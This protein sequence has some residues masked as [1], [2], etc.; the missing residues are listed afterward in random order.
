VRIAGVGR[1]P[2]AGSPKGS[3]RPA[4]VIASCCAGKGIEGPT[5][6]NAGIIAEGVQSR[7]SLGFIAG[8]GILP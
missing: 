4:M 3:I 1:S 5:L 6:L 7:L 2:L 8:A